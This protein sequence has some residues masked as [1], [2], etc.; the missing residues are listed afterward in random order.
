MNLARSREVR[1]GTYT[2]KDK[3]YLQSGRM[4]WQ[5]EN[6]FNGVVIANV[7]ISRR[8][9]EMKELINATCTEVFLV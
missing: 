9:R 1:V 3:M 5:I 7:Q 6:V 4:S 2:W 8:F